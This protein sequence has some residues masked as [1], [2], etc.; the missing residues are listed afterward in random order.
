M[1]P[2]L[3]LRLYLLV[4][5]AYGTYFIVRI[6]AKRLTGGRVTLRRMTRNYFALLALG[7]LEWPVGLVRDFKGR[8]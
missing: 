1:T 2:L 5:L 3:A 7:A 6:E 4:G 8:R